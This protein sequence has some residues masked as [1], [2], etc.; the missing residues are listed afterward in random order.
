[1]H[2]RTCSSYHIMGRKKNLYSRP[3]RGGGARAR[4][5]APLGSGTERDQGHSDP[6]TVRDTPPSQDASTHQIWDS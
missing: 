4:P 6:E 2:Y 1:M 5:Q 3:L